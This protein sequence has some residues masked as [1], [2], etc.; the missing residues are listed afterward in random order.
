MQGGP[1]NA[2][3]TD[4]R[5][6]SRVTFEV[7]GSSR[8][9][10]LDNRTTLLD[11]LR[12]HLDLIGAKKGCDHGQCGSCT[13]LLDGRRVKSCLVFAVTLDGRSVVS[14]EG[15]A[16]TDELSPL[17]AA[18]IAHDAFQCGYCTPG[19][20]CSARGMLDEVA[21]GWP[22]AVTDDLSAPAELTDAEIRERMAGNLCRC[23]AYPHIVAAVRETAASS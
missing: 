9:V 1:E 3:T 11:A 5:H 13:V 20:L 10:M 22:S 23:A 6:S 12:E 15:L 19:Q 14:V 8:E 4:Q 16:G 21:R 17:Q 18:F 7:N 2:T